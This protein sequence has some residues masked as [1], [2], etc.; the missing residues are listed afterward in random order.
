LGYSGDGGPATAAAI[1]GPQSIYIQ[2]NNI[3]LLSQGLYIRKVS[4]IGIINVFAGGGTSGDGVPATSSHISGSKGI[5]ED[6]K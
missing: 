4:T 6:N 1:H 2:S 5:I 3:I